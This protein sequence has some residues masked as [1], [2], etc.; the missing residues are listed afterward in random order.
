MLKYSLVRVFITDCRFLRLSHNFNLPVWLLIPFWAI[1]NSTCIIKIF[2]ARPCLSI[3]N[4]SGGIVKIFLL[5]SDSNNSLLFF[6][7]F[8]NSSRNRKLMHEREPYKLVNWYEVCL[9]TK[10]SLNSYCVMATEQLGYHTSTQSKWIAGYQSRFCIND[11]SI[12]CIA[13]HNNRWLSIPL[14]CNKIISTLFISKILK[15]FARVIWENIQETF[16]YWFSF[17]FNSLPWGHEWINF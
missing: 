10:L 16:F 14:L 13:S 2:D 3:I 4:F 8:Q 5:Y 6:V 15:V 1:H 11:Y 7:L 12:S 9:H 17:L